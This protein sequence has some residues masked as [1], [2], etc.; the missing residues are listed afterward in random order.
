MEKTKVN[1]VYEI[2]CS[3]RPFKGSDEQKHLTLRVHFDD[4][5]LKDVITK[6][7]A[8][9][10][11]AWQ[12]GPGRSKFGRWT[13]RQTVDIDFTSPSKAIKTRE[14]K[15]DELKVTFMKAGLPED[16]AMTLAVKAIDNPEVVDQ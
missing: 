11:I 15:I 7:L 5:P 10:R 6:A 13:D 12:N 4:V 16:Q 9:T 8:Q 2:D 3:I 14:E 1:G